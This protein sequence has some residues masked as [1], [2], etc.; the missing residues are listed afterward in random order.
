MTESL[1][2]IIEDDLDTAALYSYILEL[3][4]FTTEP[5]TT[6]DKALERLA[7]QKPDLI[8]LDLHLPGSVSGEAVLEYIN[9]IPKLSDVRVIVISGHGD[10]VNALAQEP[11]MILLRPVSVGQLS[12]L[13]TRLH[14]D[15]LEVLYEASHDELTGLNNRSFFMSRLAFSIE[16]A[17]R[18][19]DYV[20]AI[21][22]LDIDN[23]AQINATY[24]RD[25]GDELL[26]NVAHRLKKCLRLTDTLARFEKDEF[27]LLLEDIEN[28]K[29]IHPV[30]DRIQETLQTYK[31]K[32][33]QEI[34]IKVSLGGVIADDKYA[35]AE[36]VLRD[37]HRALVKAR[38]Q[39]GANWMIYEEE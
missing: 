37:A 14:P 16:R 8:L 5:I 4:G 39:E 32:D 3:V 13:V 29:N 28:P 34:E 1:A 23:F 11:D 24:G 7:S 2:F 20:Y 30:L 31:T 21:F 9:S 17:R 36:H 33:D 35:T 26:V 6:G 38:K 27:M 18:R 19:K 15:K 25:S 10:I 12:K 22:L